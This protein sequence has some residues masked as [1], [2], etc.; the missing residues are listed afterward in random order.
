M[1]GSSVAFVL[2]EFIDGILLVERQHQPV[3]R[4][5]G[6]HARRRNAETQ[7]VA[8]YERRVRHRKR[9]HR[10][11]ID[12]HMPRLRR[13]SQHGAA[14]SLV[15]RA[16]DVSAV[17]FLRFDDGQTPHDRA[18]CRE[19]LV[20]R[21]ALFVSELFRIVQ[22]RMREAIRQNHRCRH[23]R[24]RERPPPGFIHSC[25]ETQTSRTKIIFVREAANL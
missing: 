8:P 12:E 15:S 19:F 22:D 9:A 21:I 25:D 2:C 5:L 4:H 11:S 6:D 14:H 18:V 10:Q 1:R 23:H 20:K 17:D 24:P 7:A 3:A 16:E 13:E